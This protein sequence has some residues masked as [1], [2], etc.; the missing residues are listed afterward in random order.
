LSSGLRSLLTDVLREYN[1]WAGFQ[2][3][4]WTAASDQHGNGCSDTLPIY[5]ARDETIFAS[6]LETGELGSRQRRRWRESAKAFQHPYGAIR[7]F[8]EHADC[9]PIHVV[10]FHSLLGLIHEPG[11]HRDVLSTA[12]GRQLTLFLASHAERTTLPQFAAAVQSL[13]FAESALRQQLLREPHIFPAWNPDAVWPYYADQ[14]EELHAVLDSAARW[15]QALAGSAPVA[16]LSGALAVLAMFPEIPP[17][18]CDLIWELAVTTDTNDGRSAQAVAAKLSDLD[19]RLAAALRGRNRRVRTVA[20][21]WISRLRHTTAI[22]ALQS[23][24][25]WE[26]NERVLESI[27][28]ALERLGEPASPW[29]SRTRFIASAKRELTFGVPPELEWFPWSKLP[30]VHWRDT[31]VQIPTA[32]LQGLLIQLYR[33]RSPRA[34]PLFRRYC[35]MFDAAEREALGDFV[36]L[37][38]LKQDLRKLHTDFE[39]DQLAQWDAHRAVRINAGLIWHYDVG[40]APSA[41]SWPFEQW[42]QYHF[43]KRDGYGSAFG[44]RGLLA[45]CAACCRPE[46][47]TLVSRYLADWHRERAAQC[48]AL[49]RMICSVDT[50]VAQHFL[51]SE[52]VKFPGKAVG[53]ELER[54]VQT[55]AARRGWTREELLDRTLPLAGF[56]RNGTMTLKY[57]NETIEIGI[58]ESLN[59]VLLTDNSKRARKAIQ[60]LLSKQTKRLTSFAQLHRIRLYEA[61][62]MQR[63]WS[64]RVW[65]TY[66]VGHSLMR[67]LCCRLIWA[68]WREET[69]HTLVRVL[70]NGAVV[71]ASGQRISLLRSDRVRVAHEC[72]APLDETAEEWRHVC[73]PTMLFPQFGRSAWTL[74][75]ER[76]FDTA[77]RDFQGYLVDSRILHELARQ[78]GYERGP[79]LGCGWA[80]T[81]EKTYPGLGIQIR[82]GFSGNARPNKKQVTA[83]TS[84]VFRRTPVAE[85]TAVCPEE[86]LWLTQVPA[87][88]LSDTFND[89]ASIAEAGCGFDRLWK[90]TVARTIQALPNRKRS[91][92]RR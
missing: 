45:L 86:P 20:V 7:R 41:M 56:D 76:Q 21:A 60:R 10:R 74:P 13:G 66:L 62:C 3:S 36:L 48:R 32:A 83:L 73:A 5:D 81:Y 28:Q 57:S 79:A 55:L 82:L 38:W 72:M 87:I 22:P 24:A 29:L 18:L 51:L 80:Y 91:A 26:R 30:T 61:M 75:S 6:F 77:L 17:S 92:A 42:R 31:G 43:K 16:E 84:T 78:L 89:L 58:D 14:V 46:T 67:R 54:H 90:K 69:L 8:L 70:P 44:E 85:S 52:V 37:E 88:L 12:A 49:I 23:A 19:D 53:R 27:L 40:M 15:N 35:S 33:R 64:A 1:S 63:E 71:G 9:R 11:K 47:V 39:A 2:N 50:P 59:P 65:R 68:V 25:R 4:D 34:A